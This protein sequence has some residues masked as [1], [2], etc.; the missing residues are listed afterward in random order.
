MSVANVRVAHIRPQ[1]DNLREWMADPN[2]VYVGRAGVVFIDKERFPKQASPFANPFKVSAKRTRT[3]AVAEYERFIRQMLK[4]NKKLAEQFVALRGKVLGCWCAP[5]D[6]HA[7]V[8]VKML[9]ELD[10]EE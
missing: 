4:K 1:Y 6:C 8:L 3:Q 9:A 10:D 5:D 2:H 7:D